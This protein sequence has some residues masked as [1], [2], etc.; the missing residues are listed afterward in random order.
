MLKYK[1]IW[2][3]IK[4]TRWLIKFNLTIY[5]L[6]CLFSLGFSS[7]YVLKHIRFLV[8]LVLFFICSMFLFSRLGFSRVCLCVH[9]SY[10]HIQARSMRTHTTSLC[11][12]AYVCVR[13]LK[14]RH[15]NPSF[16]NSVSLFPLYDMALF[17]SFL[18]FLSLYSFVLLK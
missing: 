15:P 7:F 9:A 14:P 11:T 2:H 6:I 5:I 1:Q 12:Q 10:M 8:S 17:G 4:P 3:G 18:C 13:I 16:S